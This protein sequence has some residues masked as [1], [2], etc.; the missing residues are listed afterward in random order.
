MRSNSSGM[1]SEDR[2]VEG[3]AGGVTW[4]EHREVGKLFVFTKVHSRNQ[5]GRCKK[6]V[7]MIKNSRKLAA[8]AVVIL[9]REFA[10][11]TGSRR[12]IA[13]VER[14]AAG[15]TRG[16]VG[17]VGGGQSH[18]VTTEASRVS[19]FE[20]QQLVEGADENKGLIR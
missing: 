20:L 7:R 9:V 12:V 8:T 19:G 13:S 3:R 18:V 5:S 14:T 4:R 10:G 17:A 2:S 6:E 1:K 11:I 15:R 16:V